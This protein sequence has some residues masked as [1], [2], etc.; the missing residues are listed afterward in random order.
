ME[1]G[2]EDI[3]IGKYLPVN[4]MLVDNIYN[5]ALATVLRHNTY[6]GVTPGCLYKWSLL[7]PGG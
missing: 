1:F 2:R 6:L 5:R 3:S 7:N 4:S